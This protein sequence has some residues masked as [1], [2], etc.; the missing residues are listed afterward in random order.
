MFS[1]LQPVSPLDMATEATTSISDVI[2][3]IHHPADV[4]A[5]LQWRTRGI[6]WVLTFPRPS[7]HCMKWPSVIDKK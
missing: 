4:I 1:L 7:N 2:G 3:E 6:H 5:S